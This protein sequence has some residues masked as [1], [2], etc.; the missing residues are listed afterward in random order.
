MCTYIYFFPKF[1]GK[2]GVISW[3]LFHLIWKNYVLNW[4]FDSKSWIVD[5]FSH[6][7]HEKTPQNHFSSQ[8]VSVENNFL[9]WHFDECLDHV[10]QVPS[11]R[12]H[13]QYVLHMFYRYLFLTCLN[14]S[15]RFRGRFFMGLCIKGLK[16]IEYSKNNWF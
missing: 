8:N 12:T 15:R 10:V 4:D 5:F 13:T 9:H 6:F 2:V 1:Y 16:S 14:V 3:L 7:T 11:S